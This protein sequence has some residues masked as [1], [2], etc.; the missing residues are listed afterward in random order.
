MSPL[1]KCNGTQHKLVAVSTGYLCERD[2]SLQVGHQLSPHQQFAALDL[3][4]EERQQEEP[5][6]R[7]KDH[8]CCDGT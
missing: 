1:K 2:S 4:Y 7:D 5:Y 6:T 8:P 3:C